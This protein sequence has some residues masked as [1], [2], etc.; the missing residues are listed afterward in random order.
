MAENIKVE[1]VVDNKGRRIET[2]TFETVVDGQKQRVTETHVE[3]IPM[4]LHERVVENIAPVVT[5]RKKETYKNGKIVDSVVEELDHGTMKMNAVATNKDANTLTKEDLRDVVK[6]LLSSREPVIEK[7]PV[8]EIRLVKKK[9]VAPTVVKI[10]EEEEETVVPITVPPIKA[11]D[12]TNEWIE[13]ALY[14]VLSGQLAF[15][16]YHLV[17]KNW[18]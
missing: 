10:T 8:R 4:A 1:C 13:I 7:E 3:E 11:D 18:I 12:K 14:I 16:L 9:T 15:C 17:L 2:R 5:N 6:E